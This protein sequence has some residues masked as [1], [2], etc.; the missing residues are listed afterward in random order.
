[1][2]KDKKKVVLSP[3]MF[4]RSFIGSSLVFMYLAFYIC[5]H[6]F[7]ATRS[8]KS[9]YFVVPIVGAIVTLSLIVSYAKR[10]LKEN[11]ADFK[12]KAFIVP[13]IVAVIMIIYGVI[14]CARVLHTSGLTSAARIYAELVIGDLRKA[15]IISSIL[16]LIVSEIV[17]FLV[18]K[19]AREKML[20]YDP[21]IP[22][23]LR[24]DKVETLSSNNYG[25]G[26]ESNTVTTVD[27]GGA[28][29][30]NINWNL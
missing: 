18:T 4:L 1:M 17:V 3:V 8:E 7:D 15:Y 2:A 6:I 20:D 14:N 5:E 13:A 11:E 10:T 26:F 25:Y 24:H 29:N 16:Y 22:E 12:T 9:F 30:Q 19:N 23:E 28:S 27:T 21:T